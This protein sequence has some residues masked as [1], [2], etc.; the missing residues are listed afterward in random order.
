MANGELSNN[1]VIDVKG[2]TAQADGTPLQIYPR[3]NPVTNNQL[4]E[5]VPSKE[6]A[7]YFL[8]QSL[9]GNV[10][11]HVKDGTAQARTAL[12][13]Y[14]ED[15]NHKSQLWTVVPA[16][17]EVQPFFYIQSLLGDFVIDVK[18]GQQL[19]DGTPLQIYPKN[20]PLTHNQLWTL[21]TIKGNIFIPHIAIS[22]SKTTNTGFN[23]AATGYFPAD[24]L[25]ITYQ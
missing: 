25:S 6:N 4:W 22:K 1:D 24:P 3:N 18:G 20:N 23:M 16:P 9:L 10:A 13:V 7:G 15:L 12:Q 2:G 8:I 5:F 19:A 14:E 11:I 21:N 17:A